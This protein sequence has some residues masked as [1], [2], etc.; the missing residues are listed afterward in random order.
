MDETDEKVDETI[1]ATRLDFFVSSDL[2]HLRV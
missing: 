1:N 2:R